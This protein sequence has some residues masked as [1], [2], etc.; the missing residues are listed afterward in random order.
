MNT[1][2]SCKCIYF[3]NMLKKCKTEINAKKDK[4]EWKK[5]DKYFGCIGPNKYYTTNFY[6]YLGM[7]FDNRMSFH[8]H[9][10]TITEKANKCLCAVSSKNRKWKGS[11]RTS[12]CIYLIY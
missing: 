8:K 7:P 1:I 12:F 11:R 3:D 10:S 5:A 4:S 9:V 2:L 6:K